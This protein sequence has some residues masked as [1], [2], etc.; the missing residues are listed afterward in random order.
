M[1]NNRLLKVKEVFSDLAAKVKQH[2]T[3]VVSP[4]CLQSFSIRN[5]RLRQVKYELYE[6]YNGDSGKNVLVVEEI[7]KSYESPLIQT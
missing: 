3:D 6:Q 4:N 5:W 1:A 2:E 7:C